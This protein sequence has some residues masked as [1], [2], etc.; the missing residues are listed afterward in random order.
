MPTALEMTREGW[1][2]YL[3]AAR[4]RPSLPGLTPTEQRVREELPAR[5]REAA[6]MLKTHFGVRRV[7]LF[8][9]VAHG[10]WFAADSD[11]DLA[12]EGL[13]GKDYWMAWRG[14]EE[15]IGDRLV[16]FIDFEEA[17]ES[18]RGAIHRSGVEL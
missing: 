10:E 8:G 9:S 18:L 17:G 2:K 14:T 6:Q 7:F 3:E 11:V 5:I 1:K 16:D 13:Q 12:V 15:I 4:L